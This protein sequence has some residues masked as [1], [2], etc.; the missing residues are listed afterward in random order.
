MQH[1]NFKSFHDT[2]RSFVWWY[3]VPTLF[4]FISLF[5]TIKTKTEHSLKMY[6]LLSAT[7]KMSGQYEH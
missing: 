4:I 2:D 7:L 1:M 3:L 6:P 5:L